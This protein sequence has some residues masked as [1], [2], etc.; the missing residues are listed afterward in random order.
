M[1]SVD[2]QAEGTLH[3]RDDG[4][5]E[6]QYNFSVVQKGQI[7]EL[8][9]SVVAMTA[10][11]RARLVLDVPGGRSLNVGEMLALAEREGLS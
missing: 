7:A 10:E 1:E 2:L 8:L 11:Q 9:R 3:E 6:M 4:G 5:S